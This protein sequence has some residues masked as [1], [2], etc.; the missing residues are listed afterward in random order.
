MATFDAEK[1]RFHVK[2]LDDRTRLAERMR[3]RFN[4]CDPS[5]IYSR[6]AIARAWVVALK[7]AT[8]HENKILD[9]I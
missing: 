9:M 7:L 3:A 4:Q 1:F 5:D 8:H 6:R 2:F